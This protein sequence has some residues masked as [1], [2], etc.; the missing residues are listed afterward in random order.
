MQWGGATGH[1]LDDD[2]GV[3]GE[4]DGFAARDPAIVE[5]ERRAVIPD[6]GGGA[7][8]DAGGAD[9]GADKS[10][11]GRAARGIS[12]GSTVRAVVVIERA[13]GEQGEEDRDAQLVL[14]LGFD[15]A[16][17]VEGKT[18]QRIGA[19]QGGLYVLWRAVRQLQL[20]KV[21]AED[22][23]PAEAASRFCLGDGADERGAL[24]DGDGAV[25]A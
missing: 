17:G 8:G 21:E 9:D 4:A 24:G 7:C 1:G 19:D 16:L 5:G 25:R 22:A 3:F 23:G 6:A 2:A 20:T 11:A 15:L 13:A 10:Q 12:A 14:R 18:G